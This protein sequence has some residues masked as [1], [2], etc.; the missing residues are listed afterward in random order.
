[1]WIAIARK[2][3]KHLSRRKIDE[4]PNL[5][6]N[7]RQLCEALCL[8]FG[9]YRRTLEENAESRKSFLD[10]YDKKSEEVQDAN[11]ISALKSIV[12]KADTDPL[13][14]KQEAPWMAGF[15]KLSDLSSENRRVAEMI[16]DEFERLELGDSA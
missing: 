8:E 3:G 12:G 14:D 5:I 7:V 6:L 13:I 15:G 2:E 16:E 1:M 9:K 11:Q 10:R 4:V